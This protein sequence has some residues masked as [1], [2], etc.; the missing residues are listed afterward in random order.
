M[1]WP[2]TSTPMC[3]S[4]GVFEPTGWVNEGDEQGCCMCSST[5]LFAKDQ[6]TNDRQPPNRRFAGVQHQLHAARHHQTDEPEPHL[7]YP[8]L[9]PMNPD[10]GHN[11]CSDGWPWA[12]VGCRALA[13]ELATDGVALMILVG[14]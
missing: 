5:L 11:F 3:P 1:D 9:C 8:A 10:Y 12:D 2:F 13:L 4:L 14:V 7:I 6:T